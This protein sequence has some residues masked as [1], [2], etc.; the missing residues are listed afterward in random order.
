MGLNE[1]HH[2]G[3]IATKASHIGSAAEGTLLNGI[4][5]GGIGVNEREGAAC[6]AAGTSHNVS[7][8]AEARE[9]KARAATRLLD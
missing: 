2:I 9:A 6:L 3:V 8:W 5:A 4:R 7:I 1:L